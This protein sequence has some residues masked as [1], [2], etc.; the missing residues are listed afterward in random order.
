MLIVTLCGG[1]V[2]IFGA[3]QPLDHREQQVQVNRYISNSQLMPD[4]ASLANGRGIVV[5]RSFGDPLMFTSRFKIQGR[6]FEE[7]GGMGWEIVL[8]A[9]TPVGC[10]DPWGGLLFCKRNQP[11]VAATAGGF[12]VTWA[13]KGHGPGSYPVP[14]PYDHAILARRHGSAGLPL[15]PE[16]VVAAS[17]NQHD[18]VDFPDVAIDSSGGFVVAWAR[19]SIPGL[20]FDLDL[21]ARR[22]DVAGQPLGPSFAVNTFTADAQTQP[23]VA[24]TPDGGVVV[25]WQSEGSY[26]S[27]DSGMSIQ[28][29]RFDSNGAP[30]GS[31]FQVNSH[32]PGNQ[33]RSAIGVD[34]AGQMVVVWESWSSPASSA[35][36]PSIQAQRLDAGGN[37]IDTQFQVNEL[38]LNELGFPAVAVEP[39]GRFLVTWWGNDAVWARRFDATGDPLGSDLQIS[40][41]GVA[42]RSS[43]A[44]AVS[45]PAEY[46]V[47]WASDVGSA[48]DPLD[49]IEARRVTERW[50]FLDGFQV[51]DL[52]R[53]SVSA[54]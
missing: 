47:T 43:P 7:S 15:G 3:A 21:A 22:F 33:L 19:D 8:D 23:R 11:A 35:F 17:I 16:I 6:L 4:V 1:L 38:A 28:A 18:S 10:T 45:Q 46:F 48:G 44:V 2:P 41:G 24:A 34:A 54:P 31:E 30:V 52:S 53:W 50:I 27:D 13:Y 49:A 40:S 36:R 20:G 37:P 32:A 25:V 39:D 29:R 5:W 12:V 51:G 26:G 9:E 14:E 42:A